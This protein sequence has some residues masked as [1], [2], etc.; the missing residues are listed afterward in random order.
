ML[1]IHINMKANRAKGSSEIVM[2]GLNNPARIPGVK[3]ISS[4]TKG[5]SF[6][7]YIVGFC[8]FKIRHLYMPLPVP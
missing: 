5:I 4:L 7:K 3:G 1:T 2:E 8:M 6:Q